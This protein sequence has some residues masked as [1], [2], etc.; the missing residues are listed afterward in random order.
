M[1]FTFNMVLVWLFER[2]WCIRIP[3]TLMTKIKK[4]R[5]VGLVELRR[6]ICRGTSARWQIWQVIVLAHGL[7]LGEGL[8]WGFPL[9]PTLL[10]FNAVTRLWR[11][12]WRIWVVKLGDIQ[13]IVFYRY[14]C[15]SNFRVWFITKEANLLHILRPFHFL[16]FVRNQLR[17]GR[18]QVIK[19]S[20]LGKFILR[21]FLIFLF[22]G[23]LDTLN[24]EFLEFCQIWVRKTG[25]RLCLA[26]SLFLLLIS[27]GQIAIIRETIETFI[28]VK[29]CW[30]ALGLP[31]VLVVLYSVDRA[32]RILCN[33]LWRLIHH[34][35][36]LCWRLFFSSFSESLPR[37]APTICTHIFGR[38]WGC[39]IVLL[40]FLLVND[41]VERQRLYHFHCLQ[42]FF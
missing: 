30:V 31:K 26:S 7:L 1:L 19:S 28:T 34:Q 29:P 16:I 33:H 4:Y 12:R 9:A 23:L 37:I 35:F 13:I 22:F 17:L 36:W 14:S 11:L 27:W 24:S 32:D 3:A 6:L 39:C 5:L 18:S 2:T 15:T 10:I 20:W 40:T 42:L 38:N 8:P 41:L 21:I 25:L